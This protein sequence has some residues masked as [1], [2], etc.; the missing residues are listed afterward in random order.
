[1]EGYSLSILAASAVGALIGLLSP[2]GGVSKYLRLTVSLF[3]LCALLSPL[4][5]LLKDL[6]NGEFPHLPDREE[7]AEDY[8]DALDQA[9]D[10]ASK[11]YFVTMLTRAISEECDLDA[12]TVRC[13]VL[14]QES[15]KLLPRRV[16]VILSGGSIWKDPAPI[17]DYVISLLDCECAV[18]IEP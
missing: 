17:K 1:M 16:T 15:E 4:P 8:R 9:L 3:L 6:A 7:Q 18:A 10:E 13:T 5:S 11:D 12:E 14:W 2:S